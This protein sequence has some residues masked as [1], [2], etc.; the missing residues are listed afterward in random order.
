MG[1]AETK[2]TV[3]GIFYYGV[4]LTNASRRELERHE[5][6][7]LGRQDSGCDLTPT[8]KH[9]LLKV[10]QANFRLNDDQMG[11]IAVLQ[12]MNEPIFPPNSSDGGSTGEF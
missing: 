8:K 9:P 2:T 12:I 3:T 11:K 6:A 1:S 10:I 7:S 4:L 5:G